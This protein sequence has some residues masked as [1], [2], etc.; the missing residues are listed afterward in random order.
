MDKNSINK[1]YNNI[2][3]IIKESNIELNV[4]NQKLKAF[5]DKVIENKCNLC[6]ECKICINSKLLLPIIN[7]IEYR[8]KLIIKEANSHE[9]FK[10]IINKIRTII[11]QDDINIV[12]DEKI[13][14]N[15]NK[16][17]MNRVNDIQGNWDI[18]D[19]LVNGKIKSIQIMDPK[20]FEKI[21]SS[22]QI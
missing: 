1:C 8:N 17:F 15:I 2:L 12:S 10:A 6:N 14:R 11:K 16:F 4:Y 7:F 18:I 13:K 3:T 5:N 19:I 21:I 9:D 20:V 22:I